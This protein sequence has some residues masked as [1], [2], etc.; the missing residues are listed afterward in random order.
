[1]QMNLNSPFAEQLALYHKI[2]KKIHPSIVRAAPNEYDAE[3]IFY[4]AKDMEVTSVNVADNSA[5]IFS[6][7]FAKAFW[8]EE[9]INDNNICKD[10]SQDPILN[11]A[12]INSNMKIWQYHLQ[13]MVLEPEPLKYLE[14][15]L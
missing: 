2:F 4:D 1:M 11:D 9:F 10:E 8:G 15:F 13:Q 6:H 14:K 5:T 12:Y 3:F 7:Q